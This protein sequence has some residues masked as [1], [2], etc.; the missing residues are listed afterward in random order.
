MCSKDPDEH[1]APDIVFLF[2]TAFFFI[3]MSLLQ[4]HYILFTL[5]W[6]QD[7]NVLNN[8]SLADN[9]Y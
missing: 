6:V 5:S 9:Y 1:D 8:F 7:Q 2:C 3:S 4:M